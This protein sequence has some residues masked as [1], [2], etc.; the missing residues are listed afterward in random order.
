MPQ[1]YSV[2]D[3]ELRRNRVD[4]R[5]K[6]TN[7]V[8]DSA[9]TKLDERPLPAVYLDD[10]RYW[11]MFAAVLHLGAA[12]ACIVLMSLNLDTTGR[13]PIV[14]FLWLRGGIQYVYN[15]QQAFPLLALSTAF[16]LLAAIDHFWVSVFSF[17]TYKTCLMLG[18]QPY[19]WTEYFFSASIMNV[20]ITLLTGCNELMLLLGVA[21]LT[22][23]TM[24]F[25]ALGDHV[26]VLGA[27]RSTVAFWMGCI[28]Y[29]AVWVF[30]VY[31]FSF[32]TSIQ[33]AP[34]WV[35]S[36]VIV[37]F[38]VESLFGLQ[39]W[40]DID[41]ISKEKGFIALSLVAKMALFGLT[42][43]GILYYSK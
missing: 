12:I 4:G 36:V 42:V 29:T 30:I 3:Q 8:D 9:K 11:N 15:V 34:G 32:N 6:S 24:L 7:F 13:V 27:G 37:L 25:G 10:L 18:R 39:Q 43:G 14:L 19:R 17:K 5:Y 22:A 38:V 40:R 41:F 31:Q 35:Y 33:G 1:S 20:L 21:A 23:T 16:T 28:P 26:N 2:V